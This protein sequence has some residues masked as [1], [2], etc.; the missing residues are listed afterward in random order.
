M[1]SIDPASSDYSVPYIYDS[2]S[3]PH[4][5]TESGDDFEELLWSFYNKYSTAR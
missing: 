2:F 1:N 3:W 5:L 4:C